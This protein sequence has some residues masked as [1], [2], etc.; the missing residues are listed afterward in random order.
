MKNNIF[1]IYLILLTVFIS[2][3]STPSIYKL[4]TE[5]EHTL[6]QG[7]EVVEK[8]TDEHYTALSFEY[9][10]EQY[11]AFYLYIENDSDE[12]IIIDPSNAYIESSIKVTSNGEDIIT[13]M[14]IDP[15]TRIEEI[16]VLMSNRDSE[17]GFATCMNCLF[18]TASFIYAATSDDEEETTSDAIDDYL[19]NQEAENIDYEEDMIMFEDEKY[20]WENEILRLTTLKP[21]EKI[22]GLVYF[23]F[24]NRM[25]NNKLILPVGN[26]IYKFRYKLEKVN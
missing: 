20:F 17:Y 5:E 4:K 25:I 22:G 9:F 8:E 18:G 21:K 2:S 23:R 16:K 12:N 3:C 1:Y 6:Y 7:K 10:D 26:K 13:C 14:S 11:A 19:E 24:D 15:E